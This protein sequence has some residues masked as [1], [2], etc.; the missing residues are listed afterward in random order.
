VLYIISWLTDFALILFVFAGTRYLA[1]QQASPL[2]LG[3]LGASFFLA[4]AISNACSGRLADR[5]GR[6]RV[7]LCGSALFLASLATVASVPPESPWFY[8]AYTFVGVSVGLIYPPIMAWLGHGKTGVATRRAYLWFCLAFNL[9]I[10]SAQLSGGWMFENL[11]PSAPLLVAMGLTAVGFSC[12]LFLLKEPPAEETSSDHHEEGGDFHLAR[13]F[14]RLV[15]IANVGGMFS[16]SILWFLFPILVVDLGVQPGTHG[17]V[18]AVGRVVVMSTYCVMYLFPGWQYRFGI[19][20]IAQAIGATGLIV[21]SLADTAVGLSCGVAA[22]SALMGYNYFAGLF[23]SATGNAPKKKGL[24]FG[25]NEAS[26]GLGAA[27]GSFFGAVA[28]A[29]L[30]SRAPFC[31]AAGLIL[32]LLLV[33]TVAYW[34]LVRP[35][36]ISIPSGEASST[37]RQAERTV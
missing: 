5:V 12:L 37:S 27:G 22:L 34:K 36:T 9:G 3:L 2:L 25:L 1:E 31:I 26:L 23:Y 18:L 16:M 19:A 24:A 14:S 4:S 30:G 35:G 6:R 10:T 21:I 32:T 7:A 20:C 8:A 29:N 17:A 15:W 28:I 33:Q 13:A 11:G